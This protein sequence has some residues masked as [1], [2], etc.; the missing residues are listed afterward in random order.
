MTSFVC[1]HAR[2]HSGSRFS[3]AVH[4]REEVWWQR[5]ACT[6]MLERC[7]VCVRASVG[8]DVHILRQPVDHSCRGAQEDISGVRGQQNV[9]WKAAT[10]LCSLCFWVQ[11]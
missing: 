9:E 7:T 8:H 11:G 1:S 10:S 5:L 2:N 3:S 6:D 4:D